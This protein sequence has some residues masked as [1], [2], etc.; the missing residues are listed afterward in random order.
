MASKEIIITVPKK[1]RRASAPRKGPIRPGRR[2]EYLARR[3]KTSSGIKFFDLACVFNGSDYETISLSLGGPLVTEGRRD[4]SPIASWEA[5]ASTY[6]F[7]LTIPHTQWKDKFKQMDSQYK[8]SYA[9]YASGEPSVE[10]G[11]I[12]IV[13]GQFEFPKTGLELALI[14]NQTFQADDDPNV[15]R[16]YFERGLFRE[17]DLFSS[18]LK[19]TATPDPNADPVAID[20]DL[21]KQTNIFLSPA[22]VR[23][24]GE[25]YENGCSGSGGSGSSGSQWALLP[26][27][28]YRGFTPGNVPPSLC[29]NLEGHTSS[30]VW[31]RVTSTGQIQFLPNPDFPTF[32]FALVCGPDGTGTT[33]AANQIPLWR[34]DTPSIILDRT[35]VFNNYFEGTVTDDI[36]ELKRRRIAVSRMQGGSNIVRM[37]GSWSIDSPEDVLDFADIVVEGRPPS[38]PN[39]FLIGAINQGSKWYFKWTT[40]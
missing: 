2:S 30:A 4:Q 8:L 13:D 33:G 26:Y 24:I 7:P 1:K 6:N 5:L 40:G 38:A 28:T 23:V 21:S 12:E 17:T 16:A 34:Y 37:S 25:N 14:Y 36:E 10:Y 20:L 18:Y 29:A 22:V 15:S 9:I 3:R 31:Y 27:P 35:T 11:N 39:L 32:P 19:T